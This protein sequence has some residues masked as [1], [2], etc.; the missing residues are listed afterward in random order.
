MYYFHTLVQKRIYIVHLWTIYE[1]PLLFGFYWKFFTPLITS[2]FRWI[3]SD[4]KARHLSST[5]LS[6]LTD[7]HCIVAWKDSIYKVMLLFYSFSFFTPAFADGS[8]LESK[9]VQVSSRWSTLLSLLSNINNAV[10]CMLSP[11]PFISKS[12]CPSTNA[13]VLLPSTLITISITVT[14]M[15][16]PGIYISF[17]FLLVLPCCQPKRLYHKVP[18][19]FG[20]LIIQDRF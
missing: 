5:L 10:V 17:H 1:R 7:F 14:F 18:K 6:I 12:S 11:C 8:S 3:L 4:K 19:N 9:W 20:C 15:Q 13:F 2:Y 16:G